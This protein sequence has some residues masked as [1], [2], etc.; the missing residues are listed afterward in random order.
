M[1]RTK[2]KLPSSSTHK[3]FNFTTT[4]SLSSHRT[5]TFDPPTRDYLPINLN[6]NQQPSTP[7]AIHNLHS[8]S[9]MSQMDEINTLL[10]HPTLYDPVLKP[11]FPIVL[12][13]GMFSSL[14]LS[15][16]PTLYNYNPTDSNP[17][18]F[19][20]FFFTLA[21]ALVIGLAGLYGFD[22]RGP[23]FFRLHYWGDLLKILRGKVGAEVFVTAVPG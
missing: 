20:S 16:S 6:L 5:P 18:V 10:R 11:R 7:S 21:R 8:T 2:L 3:H 12:C 9:Q 23:A 19:P 22:V 13:H 4:P 15:L 1:H 14:S 17:H